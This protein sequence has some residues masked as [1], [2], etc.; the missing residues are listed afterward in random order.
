L[1]K[2]YDKTFKLE[3]FNKISNKPIKGSRGSTH[4]RKCGVLIEGKVIAKE[5]GRYSFY[6]NGPAAFWQGN[7]G[8]LDVK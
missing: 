7:P 8:E 3:V 2:T 1:E 5:A 6:R 4:K